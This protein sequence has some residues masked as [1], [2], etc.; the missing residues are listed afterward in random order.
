[1]EGWNFERLAKGVNIFDCYDFLVI[2]VILSAKSSRR[3]IKQ[4]MMFKP[5]GILE[6]GRNQRDIAAAV[7][8]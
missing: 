2:L 5:V 3:R 6:A 4:E 7:N 8:S 1:M